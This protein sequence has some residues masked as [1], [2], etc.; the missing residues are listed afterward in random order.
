MKSETLT[1]SSSTSSK[2]L[3]LTD[4][5]ASSGHSWNQSMH[6]QLT[7][8]G[9]FLLRTRSVVPTGEKQRTT[10]SMRRTRSM[11][12]FQTFSRVSCIPAPLHSLRQAE[13]R[14]IS[15]VLVFIDVFINAFRCRISYDAGRLG[16][17]SIE[18]CQ[19]GNK[20]RAAKELNT[21][22]MTSFCLWYIPRLMIS[23]RTF[24]TALRLGPE[25]EYTISVTSVLMTLN[26]IM[27]QWS[28]LRISA[29]KS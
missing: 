22:F 13:N 19:C 20:L 29:Q 23:C 1:P 3:L 12:N 8:A 18:I 5:R 9:N 16:S 24:H 4:T 28:H 17:V 6:V 14:K 15:S 11:K 21:E 10:L 25:P 2:N 7:T 27:W 26:A